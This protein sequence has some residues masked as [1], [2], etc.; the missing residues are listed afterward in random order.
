MFQEF[1]GKKKRINTHS[2]S[3]VTSNPSISIVVPENHFSLTV[4]GLNREMAEFETE[5]QLYKTRLGHLDYLK[6]T[7]LTDH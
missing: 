7:N 1:T 4:L 6:A 2:N 5:A 3:T